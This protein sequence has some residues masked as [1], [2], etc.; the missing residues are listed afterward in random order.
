M[1]DDDDFFYYSLVM[2]VVLEV[3]YACGDQSSSA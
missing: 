1:I 2:V 3:T